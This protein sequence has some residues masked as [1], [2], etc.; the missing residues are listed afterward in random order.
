LLS[1][2]SRGGSGDAS[3]SHALVTLLVYAVVASVG[4]L[5]L[6]RRRDA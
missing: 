2:L 6:F 3:Y 4:I 5:A 1:A